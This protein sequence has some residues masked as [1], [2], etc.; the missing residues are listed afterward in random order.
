MPHQIGKDIVVERD[1]SNDT[2][3]KHAL[4]DGFYKDNHNIIFDDEKKDRVDKETGMSLSE[5]K[6][7]KRA[8]I[9]NTNE[10]LEQQNHERLE[11]QKQVKEA[12]IKGDITKK[13]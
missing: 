6:E 11:Q 7:Q 13:I 10:M 5:Y 8:A 3:K 9:K 12:E 1:P 2:S 4:A